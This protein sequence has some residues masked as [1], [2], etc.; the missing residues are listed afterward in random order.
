[1]TATNPTEMV[2][3]ALRQRPVYI[4]RV[5]HGSEYINPDGPALAAL[6]TS[7]ERELDAAREA[8]A[9]F[10]AYRRALEEVEKWWLEQGKHHFDGAPCCIFAVR[11]AL[12]THGERADMIAFGASDAACYLYPGEDQSN[13]RA[14][15]CAGAAHAGGQRA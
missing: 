6:I 11:A 5:R 10:P 8:L 2:E 12:A 13:E 4:G 9:C 15:F 7:L 1:M 14:A 3:R